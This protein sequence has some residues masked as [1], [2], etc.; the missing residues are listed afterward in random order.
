MS[1]ISYLPGA[2]DDP[3]MVLSRILSEEGLEGVAIVAFVRTE[4]GT[5]VT[6]VAH[7]TLTEM[8]ISYAATTLLKFSLDGDSWESMDERN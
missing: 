3:K 8:Q 2:M 4:D 1:K 6:R 5:A 7:S